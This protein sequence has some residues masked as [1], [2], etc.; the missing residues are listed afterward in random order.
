MKGHGNWEGRER[1]ALGG[2]SGNVLLS[3]FR[4][5]FVKTI[6]LYNYVKLP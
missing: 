6:V 5:H 4:V 1:G 3:D 2:M